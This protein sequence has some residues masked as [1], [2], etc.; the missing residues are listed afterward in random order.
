MN[1][2]FVAKDIVVSPLANSRQEIDDTLSILQVR[3]DSRVALGLAERL[4]LVEEMQ[5][6]LFTV[7]PRWIATSLAAKELAAG[8]LGEAEEWLF[9]AT[10]WRALRLLRESLRAIQRTGRPPAKSLIVPPTD[11][12]LAIRVFP[13]H[14]LDRLLFPGITGEVWFEPGVT[15]ESI[16]ANQALVYQQTNQAGNVAL[17]L[18]A[19]N[20][21]TIPV[22]DLLHK[23]FVENQVVA[24]KLNPVNAYLGPLLEVVL[25]SLIQRGFVGLV[26]GGTAEGAYLCH[27]PAI[28]ELHMTGSHHTFEASSANWHAS[29]LLPSL[30]LASW[31]I[32][33]QLSSFPAPGARPTS[34]GRRC[35]WRPR[36]NG[37]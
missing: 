24:L 1:V 14:Q 35:N 21:S 2:S 28:D 32:S 34:N 29:H 6:A 20:I 5:Q 27:H 13:H 9:L 23:L 31:V 25:R 12:Q 16:I 4:V 7:A 8:T 33:A 10:I 18:G 19:G 22:V 11:S 26:Y 3:K 17:V 37:G 30:S 15:A 36:K